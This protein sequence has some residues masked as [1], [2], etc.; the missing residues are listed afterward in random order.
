A[1]RGGAALPG[2]R[3]PALLRRGGR[4]LVF[5]VFEEAR[6]PRYD[7]PVPASQRAWELLRAAAADAV[8]GRSPHAPDARADVL[9]QRGSAPSAGSTEQ[10]AAADAATTAGQGAAAPTDGTTGGTSAVAAIVERRR[11][12][13][14]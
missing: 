8:R 3:A 9:A 6:Y 1:R 2:G 4:V 10:F 11:R 7:S 14:G 13:P 12:G 5:E